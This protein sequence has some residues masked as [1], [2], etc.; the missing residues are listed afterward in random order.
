MEGSRRTTSLLS[1]SVHWVEKSRDQS[2]LW[3]VKGKNELTQKR[4]GSLP[5]K[6]R[7]FARLQLRYNQRLPLE[8]LY[9]Y[10]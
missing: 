3:G 1:I 8:F 9:L 5:Y 7:C 10:S 6:L 4:L 2:K